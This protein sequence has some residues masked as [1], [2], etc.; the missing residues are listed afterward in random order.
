[1]QSEASE[2]FDI[3]LDEV[4][5]I[6]DDIQ[7]K[8][9]VRVSVQN[10]YMQN[11]YI[12]LSPPENSDRFKVLQRNNQCKYM[13]KKQSNEALKIIFLPEVCG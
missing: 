5:D 13:F 1:M 7:R 3:D 11:K 4:L 9:F 10:K 2:E 8:I 6:E 12:L